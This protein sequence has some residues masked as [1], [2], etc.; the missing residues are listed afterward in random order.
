MLERLADLREGRS[1]R[2]SSWDTSGRNAD[3]WAVEAGETKTLAELKGA[4][5]IRHIWFTIGAPDAL[6][7]RQAV[8]RMHWDG[9]QHPSV[10][11]PVGDFFGIGHCR[12]NSYSCA[13]MNMSTNAGAT[14]FNRHAAM[15]CY[16]PMPFSNGGGIPTENQATE[17][18]GGG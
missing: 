13:V 8:L 2:V 7:L 3:A 14:L 5:V 11:A 1:K 16:W 12:V 9:Q 18:T 17:T 10:E 6:Y 15:N 4:G